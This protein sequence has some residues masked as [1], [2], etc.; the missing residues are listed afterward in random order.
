MASDYGM[1]FP[2]YPSPL[3]A[4]PARTPPNPPCLIREGG[5]QTR[6]RAEIGE[7]GRG[8]AAQAKPTDPGG[9]GD[10]Q[11]RDEHMGICG[12][13]QRPPAAVVR[14]PERR[15]TERVPQ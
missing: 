5:Y 6:L 9:R 11:G 2:N 4:H 8:F 13:S 15:R 1:H 14:V 3:R 12:R 10:V 7:R